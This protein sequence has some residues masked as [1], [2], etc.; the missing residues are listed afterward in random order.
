MFK[1]KDLIKPSVN[2]LGA[3]TEVKG[4]ISIEGDFRTDGKIYGN[5]KCT[6]KITIGATSYIEGQIECEDAE[7]A[8][9]IKGNIKANGLVI[10]KETS[11][12]TGNINTNKI[13]IETGA[14]VSISCAT[15]MVINK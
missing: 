8:G 15:D 9:E 3:I 2:M 1:T 12:F 7:I 4:D 11:K 14:N 6:G 13:T 5:I 10:L